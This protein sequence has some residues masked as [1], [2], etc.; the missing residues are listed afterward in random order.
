V[1]G[2][3]GSDPPSAEH[4][5]EDSFLPLEERLR[6]EEGLGVGELDIPPLRAVGGLLDVIGV[7]YAILR[8]RLRLATRAESAP[9]GE[10]G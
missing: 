2:E 4:P 9:P 6:P 1:G 10:V 3:D 8:G 5:P 7:E